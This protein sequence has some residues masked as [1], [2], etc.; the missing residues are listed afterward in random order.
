MTDWRK[1]VKKDSPFLY[2]WDIEGKSP[3][4]V[5]I[6]GWDHKEAYCPGKGEK[7][8]LWCLKFRNA[9]K[10]LGINVTNGNLIEHLHGSDRD[11]WPGK[12][13]T[14]RVAEC[15]GE[16]CIRIHAPGARLPAQCK[17][18]KYIDPEPKAGAAS[19]NDKAEGKQEDGK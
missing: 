10:V 4:T 18:F 2:Y 13:I 17:R 8:V 3:V 16:K 9:G 14:L 6:E 12:Q 7:G 5:T 19:I 15:A 11:K 1:D